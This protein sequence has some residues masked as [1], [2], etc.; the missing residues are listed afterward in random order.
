MQ[1]DLPQLEVLAR[2]YSIVIVVTLALH[3]WLSLVVS[4]LGTDGVLPSL[5]TL[6]LYPYPYPY[7]STK[8]YT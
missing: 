4:V 7:C 8:Y 2:L 5:T 1:W 3:N 6:L